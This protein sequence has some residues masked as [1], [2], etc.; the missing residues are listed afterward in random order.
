MLST[1]GS[2]ISAWL[3]RY[4]RLNGVRQILTF[5]KHATTK[6]VSYYDSFAVQLQHY[7]VASRRKFPPANLL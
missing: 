7:S 6:E 1:E 2:F 3:D 5:I 4:S